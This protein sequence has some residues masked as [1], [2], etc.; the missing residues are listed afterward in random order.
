MDPCSHLASARFRFG[1]S[2][3]TQTFHNLELHRLGGNG[4]ESPIVNSA[5][6]GGSLPGRGLS[7]VQKT[8]LPICVGLLVEQGHKIPLS[9]NVSYRVPIHVSHGL[10]R[11]SA[12]RP[13]RPMD[14]LVRSCSLRH[15]EMWRLA[16]FT[17]RRRD[18]ATRDN[19]LATGLPQNHHFGHKKGA[20][21]SHTL[22]GH[23]TRGQP[24]TSE[25]RQAEGLK[26]MV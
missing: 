1:R 16:I 11:Q 8:R 26:V 19:N 6:A 18:K 21:K 17:M 20:G 15:V 14:S 7:V 2:A 24:G 9:A 13:R 4:S 22:P 25:L 5:C 23:S 3:S 12:I 10:G